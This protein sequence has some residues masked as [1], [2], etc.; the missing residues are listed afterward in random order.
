VCVCVYIR[1]LDI[2]YHETNFYHFIT[3]NKCWV[4]LPRVRIVHWGPTHVPGI[5]CRHA[6]RMECTRP[7]PQLYSRFPLRKGF[8]TNELRKAFILQL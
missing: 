3:S 1:P 5:M 8:V 7:V 4:P 6:V 2:V